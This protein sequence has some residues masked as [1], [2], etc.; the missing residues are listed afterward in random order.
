MKRKVCVVSGSRADYGLLRLVMQKIKE[1][2]D[3]E[4]QLIVTGMHLSE[5]FGFTVN[6]IESDGF[7][8][9]R[10]I[11]CLSASDDSISIAEAT[12][13]SLAGCSR[14]FTELSPDVVLVLGDRFEILAAAVAALFARIPVAHI[15]GGEL[16]LGSYDESMRHAITKMSHIHFVANDV[17]R[18]RVAQLGEMPKNIYLVGGLGVD[19]IK[20]IKLLERKELEETLG[21]KFKQKSL[22]ITFHPSTLEDDTPTH[23]MLELL[24]ALSGRNDTTM[25]FTLPNSDTGGLVL[26][27]LIEDFVQA[28]TNCYAF[29]SLGQLLY[30]S[31]MAQVDGVVGNSSSGITEAP[32]L[33]K[34]TINIGMRQ[35]GRVQS[36]NVINC[37]ANRT[38][39]ERAILKLY[40]SDFREIVRK[41]ESPHGK[42]G[43]SERIVEILCEI[44]LKGLI[45]KTFYD[46]DSSS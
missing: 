14:A 1:N 40:S 11:E 42:G 22:L 33:Q 39:I 30:L 6:E 15:H 44:N 12:S 34:G 17:Y 32:V 8:I 21:L 38:E 25:I 45:R 27:K 10:R 9:N 35:F 26:I 3:L 43:A 28:N 29:K 13:K 41:C 31:C 37:L 24:S 20:A 5:T 19:S 36:T 18:K 7:V 2:P 16:T 23:Q 4:L 46:L